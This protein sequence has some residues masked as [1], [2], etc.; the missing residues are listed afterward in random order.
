MGRYGEDV[1]VHTTLDAKAQQSADRAVTARAAI[2][3]RESDAYYGGAKTKGAAEGQLQG[4]MVALDPATGGILAL[5]GAATYERG[6]FNRALY[7]RRQP[8]SVF[9]PFVYAAA[10]QRGLTAATLVD[11]A[12]VSVSEHGNVWTPANYGGEYFGTLTLRNALAKS[13]NAAAV[14]VSRAVGEQNVATLARQNGI[15]SELA[16]VPAIALGALEVTPLELVAAYAPFANG[17]FRI[18]PQLVS[19]IQ[20]RG[21][22]LIWEGSGERT[23]VMDERDAF[24]LTSMLTSVVDEGTGNAIRSHGIQGVVAGKTGTTNDAA[25]LWFVGYTPTIV[26]G[27]WF[28]FDTPR[29]ISGGANG[30][31]HAAPAWAEFYRNGW[32]DRDIWRGWDP[33]AG[34]VRRAI[35]DETG[36]LAG[37]WC[38]H[39]R[40]EWFKV[41]HQPSEFC[42]THLGARGSILE[43]L[44]RS[45]G[46]I[47][48]R[49]NGGASSAQSAARARGSQQGSNGGLTT[50][51][52][53][54]GP[55]G[56]GGASSRS[57]GT[58]SRSG[59]TGTRGGG[60]GAR[61][62]SGGR[63]GGPV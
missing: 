54:N 2:I 45:I 24:L 1:V 12:P 47:F 9:K 30:G 33:P 42:A 60:S 28:G 14:R 56:S 63:G 32:H 18:T 58:S 57:D 50:Q 11:D 44:G 62:G 26:A 7:A 29:T 39:V 49:G 4:A 35:D 27:F 17:G 51:G 25:D 48:R 53:R 20:T 31:R 5:V 36:H 41:E 6:G 34:L 8:G 3:Q 43:R 21:G 15:N 38:P 59:G 52:G 13:A 10:L 55:R 23:R 46:N 40:D 19:R 22:E 37:A 61:G 16:P